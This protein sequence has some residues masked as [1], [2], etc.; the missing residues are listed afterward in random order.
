M[1]EYRRLADQP[2]ASA[3][4]E[5]DAAPAIQNAAHKLS[6]SYEFPYLAHAPME[7]LDAVVK[8]T[9]S[10]CEIWAGDQFQ[11]VDQANAA[12]IAGLRSRAGQHPYAVCRRQLRPARQRRI[13]LHRRG[14]I[15]CQ[16]LRGR[17]HADQ[18]AV[19][20][21]GR[22]PRRAV[23]ADVLS[24]AR[25]GPERE[26]GAHRLAA[27]HR[28]PVHHGGR[29][30]S[31]SWSRT[32]STRPRSRARR[33]SRTTFRTFRVELSTTK[34]GVPVLWWR[35]VGSSHTTF[36]VEAF[37]D[38]VAHAAGEDPFTF[39]RGLLEHQ[40]RMKAVLELAAEKAGWSSGPMP[41]GKG[42]GIAVAEAFK[43]YRGAGG[44]GQRR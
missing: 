36:A 43:T 22:P 10:S 3:R 19:D 15:D 31:R 37:I 24:Q 29:P 21:R 41:K 13:G 30:P 2:A 6:A 11:T 26:E 8:L 4:K 38:E 33:T 23:S 35:V 32:A 40:P 18:A 7:P 27:C 14:G 34:T 17:R 44:R 25:G 12:K 20:A 28:R 16:G 5:G 42:R 1:E 39:R 9:A